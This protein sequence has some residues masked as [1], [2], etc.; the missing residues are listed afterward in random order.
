MKVTDQHDVGK[1]QKE[2]NRKIL[3]ET[4]VESDVV[5]VIFGFDFWFY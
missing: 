3:E 1:H 5:V 4:G 2:I